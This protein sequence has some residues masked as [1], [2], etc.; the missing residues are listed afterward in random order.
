MKKKSKNNSSEMKI[1]FIE[2]CNYCD[3]PTGGH[4]SF[5]LHMLGTFGNQLKLVGITT[6]NECE[7]CKWAKID[8]AGVTYDYF[9]VANIEKGSRKP[10]IP[11]R[12]TAFC[13]IRMYINKCSHL[14]LMSIGS[15]CLE[16]YLVQPR[17]LT[18]YFNNL[19]PFNILLMYVFI[20]IAAYL[21]RCVARVW[22][23]TFNGDRYEWNAVFKLY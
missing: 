6:E 14:F 11:S 18:D 2:L 3:Y 23:Q 22:M 17:I 9:N 19:F 21:L 7:G 16:I 4:L 1:L 13:Q 20:F 8:I 15:L 12:I 5:A 10:L